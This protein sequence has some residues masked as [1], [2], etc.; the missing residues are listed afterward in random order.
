MPLRPV[1]EILQSL[2]QLCLLE[3]ELKQELEEATND[4]IQKVIHNDCRVLSTEQARRIVFKRAF[5]APDDNCSVSRA[6][7]FKIGDRVYIDNAITS[8][9]ELAN[10]GDQK[11]TVKA[12][13]GPRYLI[14]TDNGLQTHRLGK[15]LLKLTEKNH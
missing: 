4:K 5:A 6:T 12:V 11:A 10:K 2:Q 8:A 7:T 14:T 3:Q 1:R 13:N 15:Y 9:T